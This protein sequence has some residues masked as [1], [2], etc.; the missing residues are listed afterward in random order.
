MQVQYVRRTG[1]ADKD[2][3]ASSVAVH[4]LTGAIQTESSS[5]TTYWSASTLSS[6]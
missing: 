5:L 2:D 1:L 6:R 4:D 3:T